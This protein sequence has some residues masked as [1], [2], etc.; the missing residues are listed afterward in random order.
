MVP[1]SQAGAIAAIDLCT[2]IDSLLQVMLEQAGSIYPCLNW[3]FG[4]ITD[5]E[6]PVEVEI[7]A[8]SPTRLKTV[9]QGMRIPILRSPFSHRLYE[10]HRVS[11][12]GED[13]GTISLL[14]PQFTETFA[15]TSLM[16]VPLLFEGK[17]IGILFAATFKGENASVPSESQL[18]ALQNVARVGAVMLDRLRTQI[19]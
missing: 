9:Y 16:G 3:L 15:L 1:D 13:K 11:Y 4:E 12:V 8:Y 18:E 7:L 5:A 6:N 19:A 2:T 10:E 17:I 14:N